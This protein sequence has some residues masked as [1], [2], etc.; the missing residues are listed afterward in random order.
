MQRWMGWL[1]A[2]LAFCTCRAKPRELFEI[3]P[4]DQE[5][6][7]EPFFDGNMVAWLLDVGS[8]PLQISKYIVCLATCIHI[9][10]RKDIHKHTCT[11]FCAFSKLKH[12][13]CAGFISLV[14]IPLS[15]I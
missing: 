14:L 2:F 8:F 11:I 15:P 6:G 10:K 4:E 12:T 3:G 7:L 1:V 9:K 5:T 13:L